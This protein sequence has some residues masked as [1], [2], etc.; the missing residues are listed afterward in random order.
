[1]QLK[2]LYVKNSDL[3]ISEISDLLNS[4]DPNEVLILVNEII[5]AEKIFFVGVGR[6][7]LS[8]QC[9]CKR[10]VHLGFESNI[11][12]GINEKAITSKDLLIIGSGSGES[13]FPVGIAKKALK[14]NSKIALITST[15]FSTLKTISTFSVHLPAPTKNDP[16]CGISSKQPMS[17]LFDQALHIFSDIVCMMIINKKGLVIKDLWENHANLE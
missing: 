17:S 9:F 5:M 1:M 3:I 14:L 7:S 15:K 8:L 10:L 13:I 12:G 11:V 16:D 4:V 2:E 6:V